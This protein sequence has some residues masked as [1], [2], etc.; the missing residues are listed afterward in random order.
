VAL[1]A[2]FVSMFVITVLCATGFEW[3]PPLWVPAVLLSWPI[4]NGV[5]IVSGRHSDAPRSEL[6]EVEIARRNGARSTALDLTLS[7]MMIPTAYLVFGSVLTDG[8]D[9][10]MAYAGGGMVLVALLAGIFTPAM[11]LAWNLPDHDSST[12]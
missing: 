4:A 2:A 7:L 9:E 12:C 5:E 3:A 1:A 11:I 6:D 10:H 8:K